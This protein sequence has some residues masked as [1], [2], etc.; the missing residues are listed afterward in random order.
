MILKIYV[1]NPISQTVLFFQYYF[2]FY[3][4]LPMNGIADHL[5][6]KNQCGIID[7]MI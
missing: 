7:Q 2:I 4:T 3:E 5:F 6:R 1:I